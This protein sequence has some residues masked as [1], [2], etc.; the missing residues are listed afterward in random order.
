[1][2]PTL[3]SGL[4][5]GKLFRISREKSTASLKVNLLSRLC[6][7]KVGT[8]RI[9]VQ[10]VRLAEESARTED[11]IS[12]KGGKLPCRVNTKMKQRI[13]TGRDPEKV[14]DLINLKIKYAQSEEEE[15]K[16]RLTSNSMPKS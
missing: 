12:E 7:E 11:Y 6:E 13:L 1:M 15:K 8:T 4:S 9:E 3:K 5:P 16:K 14:V 2:N 10:A